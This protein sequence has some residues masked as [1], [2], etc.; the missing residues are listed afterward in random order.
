LTRPW[1]QALI[2]VPSLFIGGSAD[3]VV[4][5]ADQSLGDRADPMGERFTD[6]RGSVII[7]GAGHWLQQEAPYQVNTAILEFLS[8]VN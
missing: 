1:H 4:Q 2:T 8:D 3:F 6:F 5:S 7:D